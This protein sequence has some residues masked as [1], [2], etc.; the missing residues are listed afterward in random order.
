MQPS[1]QPYYRITH[2]FN[3]VEAILL[4]IWEMQSRFNVGVRTPQ[5][6]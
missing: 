2:F 4:I 5:G 6:L 1:N 3:A